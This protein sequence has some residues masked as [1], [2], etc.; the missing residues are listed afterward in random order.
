MF[1]TRMAN[2]F[3]NKPKRGM[4]WLP[5]ITRCPWHFLWENT[6]LWLGPGYMIRTMSQ[7]SPG[8][9][10][11]ELELKL[12]RASSLV[13][14][15]ALEPLWY[16]EINEV[17]FTGNMNL[18]ETINLIKN[19]NTVKILFSNNRKIAGVGL[20]WMIIITKFLNRTVIL[21]IV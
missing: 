19:T 5:V 15:K 18:V 2:S 11:T 14:D 7:V 3:S 12:K 8:A 4:H 13:I 10:I 16:G 9:S 1:S 21:I 17:N 6:N 20:P